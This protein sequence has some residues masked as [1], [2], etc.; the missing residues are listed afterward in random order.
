[1]THFHLTDSATPP[2]EPDT[3]SALNGTTWSSVDGGLIASP[4]DK[5][6]GQIPKCPSVWRGRERTLSWHTPCQGGVTQQH[7][8]E[9]YIAWPWRNWERAETDSLPREKLNPS[10]QDCHVG[11]RGWWLLIYQFLMAPH[12]RTCPHQRALSTKG[13]RGSN[14][15]SQSPTNLLHRKVQQPLP[16]SP[17]YHL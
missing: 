2:E 16:H 12:A 4:L 11:E 7:F 14:N 9:N 15:L 3:S 8:G 6:G 10:S 13:S 17:A 5:T 1:M